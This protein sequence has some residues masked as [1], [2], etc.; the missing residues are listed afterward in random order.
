MGRHAIDAGLPEDFSGLA[1]PVEEIDVEQSWSWLR[2]GWRDIERA[3]FVSLTFGV[4]IAALS[5]AIFLGLWW[6]QSLPY[7]FPA[8]A[9]F[10]FLAPLVAVAFYDIS[11]RL[12]KGQRVHLRD[13]AT[14][15]KANPGGIFTMGL[16]MMLFH[17][18]WLRMAT[19]LYPIY[20]GTQP[21]TLWDFVQDIFLTI[22]GIPF[23]IVGT[24]V[25]GILAAIAFAISVVSFPLLLDRDVG[26]PRAIA[27]SIS[28]TLINWRVLSGWAGL[29]VIFTIAGIVTGGIGLALT[30]PLIGHASWH[31]YRD[32]VTRPE[33]GNN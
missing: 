2:Q 11:R 18:V 19:L 20:F 29:V 5:I 33:Q 4:A 1:L 14:A 15:W 16:V 26:V 27:T 25:G 12:E 22:H 30:M 8:S 23:L 28:A 31:A 7:A 3:P 10:F 17:L 32:L 24:I 9:G 13:V 21:G 6:T